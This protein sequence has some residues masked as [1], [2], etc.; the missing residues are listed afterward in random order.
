M[1]PSVRPLWKEYI[2]MAKKSFKIKADLAEALSETINSATNNVGELHIEIVPLRKIT[3]DSDNP[4]TL[5]LT[6]KDVYQEIS[7]DDPLFDQKITEQ[8]SLNSLAKSIKEQGVLN[9]IIVYKNDNEYQLVAGERRTLASILAK[10][11]DIPARIL[12]SK[13]DKLKLSLLQWIENIEREDLTLWERMRNLEK[14]VTAYAEAKNKAPEEI[15]PTEISKLTSCSL[16]Q[17]VNYRLLLNASNKIKANIQKGH[18]KNIEK[19]ALIVKS[20]VEIQETLLQAAI[21][22][23]TLSKL[24]ILSKEISEKTRKKIAK[25]KQNRKK[26]D[27]GSTN[28]INAAQIIIRTIL[29]HKKF[30]HLDTEIGSICWN[31]EQ[32]VT[33]AFKKLIKLLEKI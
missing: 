29:E 23:T 24:K 9:P 31:S 19:V 8:K 22:G 16:Q 5:S 26:I 30:Q 1:N 14:I 10:K 7:K 18:I 33:A 2:G 28:S 27:F 15:S 25:K 21:N 13:P 4:R 3:L 32:S 6:F 11:Q 20:D 17:G 12:T